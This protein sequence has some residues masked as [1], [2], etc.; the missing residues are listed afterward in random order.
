[1]RRIGV[2][3]L[4]LLILASGSWASGGQK[5]GFILGGGLGAGYLTN[6]TS[7]SA[8]GYKWQT[9]AAAANVKAGYAPSDSLEL[10]AFGSGW[11]IGGQVRKFIGVA[12]V[13]MTKYLSPR[14]SGFLLTGGLGISFFDFDRDVLSP[15]LGFLIGAGYAL[16]KHWSLQ[17]DIL[18]AG[19]SSDPSNWLRESERAGGVRLTL[20]GLVF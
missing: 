1:M 16:S 12:G 10:Y 8:E 3:S 2:F 7:Y 9:F 20:N 6:L 19:I 5:K 17:V 14:G 15:D 13:G 4:L 11:M 18:Y